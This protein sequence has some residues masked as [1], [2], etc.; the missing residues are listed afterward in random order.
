MNLFISAI[1]C[2]GLLLF[3]LLHDAKAG[4]PR[5][6]NEGAPSFSQNKSDFSARYLRSQG[7]SI[8]LLNPINYPLGLQYD[9]MLNHRNSVN[10]GLGLFSMGAGFTH[11]LTDPRSRKLNYTVGLQSSWLWE[12]EGRAFFLPLG[13]QYWGNRHFTYALT[14]GPAWFDDPEFL[15]YEAGKIPF[16]LG[17]SIGYRMGYDLEDAQLPASSGFKRMISARAGLV[18]PFLAIV[19]EY[20][21][22]PHLATELSI[23]LIGAGVGANVYYPALR[24]GRVSMKIGANVGVFWGILY[25]DRVIHLPIGTTYLTKNRWLLGV[26]VGPQIFEDFELPFG[27]SARIGRNF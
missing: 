5:H 18:N 25:T 16:V 6:D 9:L 21:L 10:L 14:L 3:S 1:S 17:A 11:Y 15:G 2:V 13:I 26:D 24:P 23:G 20:L 8:G 22:T 12:S 27:I 7:I 19:Y 4:V